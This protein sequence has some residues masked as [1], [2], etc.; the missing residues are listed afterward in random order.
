M[1]KKH[2]TGK[3]LDQHVNACAPAQSYKGIWVF[4]VEKKQHTT[5][6]IPDWHVHVHPNIWSRIF[7]IIII[8]IIINMHETGF[9]Y[10]FFIFLFFFL[11]HI[12]SLCTDDSMSEQ[13]NKQKNERKKE[14]IKILPSYIISK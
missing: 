14:R 4:T 2:L 12:H 10:Y 5:T 1:P 3:V 13:R 8:I 6:K 9:F 7:K 11:K